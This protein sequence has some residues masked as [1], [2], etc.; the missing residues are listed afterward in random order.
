MRMVSFLWGQ[1]ICKKIVIQ[2]SEQYS[3]DRFLKMS[4]SKI[5]SFKS[6]FHTHPLS[7]NMQRVLLYILF[8]LLPPVLYAQ[9]SVNEEPRHKPVF[10]NS[11]VRILNVLLPPGDTTQYHIHHTPSVFILFTNTTTGSQLKGGAPSSSRSVAGTSIFENL[12]AP[13]IRVHRVWNMDTD[14]FHVMDIE[15]LSVDSGFSQKPLTRQN[16]RL[17]IDTPWARVYRLT[18]KNSNSFMLSDDQRSLILISLDT[19]FVQTQRGTAGQMEMLKPGSFFAVEP[20]S[21]FVLKNDGDKS[22]RFVVLE[23]PEKK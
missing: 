20:R 16:M 1:T 21:D 9:V 23:V 22:A 17:E 15:L 14:T 4:R 11:Q 10:E 8:F 7:L 3:T 2:F 13:H 18:L 6:A 5:K 12:S 19:S